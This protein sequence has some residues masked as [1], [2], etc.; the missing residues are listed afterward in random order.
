MGTL[1]HTRASHNSTIL[2][3]MFYFIRILANVEKSTS[4]LP[5]Q[6]PIPTLNL[7]S[8]IYTGFYFYFLADTIMRKNIVETISIKLILVKYLC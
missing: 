6:S 2:S 1:I 4:N 5:I 7:F 3:F 8:F